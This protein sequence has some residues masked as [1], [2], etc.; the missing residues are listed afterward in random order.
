MSELERNHLV[1]KTIRMDRIVKIPQEL[2]AVARN[3][4]D[5]RDFALLKR[6]LGIESV[7]Q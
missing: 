5:S 4:V 6:L 2:R 7:A 1:I 3:V